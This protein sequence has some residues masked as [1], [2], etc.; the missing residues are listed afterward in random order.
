MN[1]NRLYSNKR[2]L[3]PGEKGQQRPA[4]AVPASKAGDRF[5]DDATLRGDRLPHLQHP[6]TRLQHLRD[7]LERS[8]ALAGTD[9]QSSRDDQQQHQLH[10]LRDL[11]QKV[12]EDI[13]QVIL[14]HGAVRPGQGQPGIPDLRRIDR[15]EYDQYRTQ[16]LHQALSPE[17]IEH[18]QQ[19]Q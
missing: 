19:E 5:G 2:V 15:Y 12:Q 4:T 17:Q 9:G 3:I 11:R 7:V 16:E 13:P 1:D 6:A 10:N 14:Q 18:H 8:A